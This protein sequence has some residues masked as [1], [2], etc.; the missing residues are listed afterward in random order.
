M[1][2]KVPL[3]WDINKCAP[4]SSKVYTGLEW[5]S[6]CSTSIGYLLMCS[7]NSRGVHRS[8]VM[9]SDVP[10]QLDIYWYVPVSSEM[11]TG[12]EWCFPSSTSTGYLLMYSCVSKV[13]RSGVMS[14]NV[15]LQLHINKYVL[16]SLKVCTGSEWCSPRFHFNGISTNV[17]LPLQRCTQV[18][19]DIIHVLQSPGF[20]FNG[21]LS[22]VFL[23]L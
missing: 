5:H 11:Y 2:S 18:W 17:L 13:H 21:I 22:N 23:S 3:Q 1:F 8:G 20:H 14:P 4:A 12:L 19:S 7:Y 15:P 9:F 10:L 16:V 6:P